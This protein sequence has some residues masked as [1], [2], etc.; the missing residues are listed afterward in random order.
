MSSVARDTTLEPHNGDTGATNLIDAAKADSNLQA[1]A[2]KVREIVDSLNVHT[3]NDDL[4]ADAIVRLFNLH[5]EVLAVIASEA[6]WQ[7]K[8]ACACATTANIVLTGEQTIDGV[9]TSASRVL[10]KDQTLGEQNGIYLSS[11]GAWTRVTD[12]D[13]AAEL[14]L[15]VVT[16]TSGTLN[17]GGGWIQTVAPGVITV[18]TTALTWIR[19]IGT[20]TWGN[21][22]VASYIVDRYVAGVDFTAGSTTTLTLSS[23][24][25]VANAATITFDGVTQHRSTFSIVGATLTFTTAIPLGVLEVE[26]VH[27]SVL[28]MGTP[29]NG[30]VTTATIADGNVTLAKLAAQAART[31]IAN[32][33]AG[34]AV[35]TAVAVDTLTVLATGASTRRSL[36]AHFADPRNVKDFGA[37]GDGVTSD[38]AA[39]DAALAVSSSLFLPAGTY[40]YTGTALAKYV[41][42]PGK[43]VTGSGTQT[44]S[45]QFQQRI[46]TTGI[47]ASEAS[48][49]GFL[50]LDWGADN[51][52]RMYLLAKAAVTTGV[53]GA[54]KIFGDPYHV[55]NTAYRDL[56]IYF[57]ADQGGDDGYNAKG[58]FWINSKTGHNNGGTDTYA[59]KNCDI[60]ISFQDG[61][62]VAGRWVYIKNGFGTYSVQV[63]GAGDPVVA[64]LHGTVRAE[65]NGDFGL[66]NDKYFRW[67]RADGTAGDNFYGVDI[68]DRFQWYL[69]GTQRMQLTPS[70][71][72]LLNVSITNT[73]AQV[74]ALSATLDMT[75]TDVA[76]FAH[77]SAQSVT[78]I[79]PAGDG[80]RITLMFT[81]G[82]TTI[83][84]GANVKLAG[85]A[86]F[87]GTADDTLS[88][89]YD[90]TTGAW[91][92]TGRSVN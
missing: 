76:R 57:S 78:A 10:V 65:I 73:V 55:L 39:I 54:L 46:G 35:P 41:F 59:D 71:K 64:P 84:N 92:E 42:G 12:A 79:T 77:P 18:G 62:V 49:V 90:N 81:N 4:L 26:A 45:P 8:A 87:V 23:S 24:D 47:L 44:P 28:Q 60:G 91:R 75:I 2:Q 48:Y 15:A 85:A 82:F 3:R 70:G 56:G 80:Q 6:A 29:S 40:V 83:A 25:A 43:I 69:R 53:G 11:A 37:V 30:S 86:N 19:F 16:V 89:V 17:H 31:V 21:T 51:A 74:S 88:L 66:R 14:G 27:G 72:L 13:S 52:T 20:P 50:N 36:A 5:P 67:L 32:D 38:T 34:S 7:P 61:A 22:P 68:N 9:L 58:C 1:L 63:I 33:T